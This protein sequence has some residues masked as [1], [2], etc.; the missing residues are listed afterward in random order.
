MF[1]LFKRKP[2]A[3]GQPPL[4]GSK[5]FLVPASGDPFPPSAEAPAITVLETK[6]GWVRYSIGRGGPFS[7]NRLPLKTFLAIC[8]PLTTKNQAQE[9]RTLALINSLYQLALREHPNT[10]LQTCHSVRFVGPA[11]ECTCGATAHNEK[12]EAALAE[13][14]A[15]I[16]GSTK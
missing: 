8:K 5:W 7:D 15:E 16:E 4:P 9:S 1:K 3:Q 10:N 13:L 2:Q 6:E 11:G 14:L 12:V